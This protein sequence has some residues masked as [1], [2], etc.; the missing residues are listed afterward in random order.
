MPAGTAAQS[1]VIDRNSVR[2]AGRW[3]KHLA[4]D[5]AALQPR[6]KLQAH[7]TLLLVRVPRFPREWAERS[8]FVRIDQ[9]HPRPL[10]KMT[11]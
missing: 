11:F 6:Q 4:C 5:S 3:E 2:P 1:Q 10:G 8:E 9:G 7:A